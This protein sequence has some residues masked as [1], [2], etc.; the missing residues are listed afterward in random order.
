M[1]LPIAT[2]MLAALVAASPAGA[3]PLSRLFGSPQLAALAQ[4]R[5][6]SYRRMVASTIEGAAATVDEPVRLDRGGGGA[7]VE[8]TLGEGDTARR[9]PPFRGMTGNPILMVFLE[10]VVGAASAASGGSPFYLRSRIKEAMRERMAETPVS[11]GLGGRTVPG[12]EISLRPFEGDPHAAELGAF[13]DLRLSFVMAEAA[14]G[15]FVSLAAT[16]GPG[17]PAFSEEIR[18]DVPQ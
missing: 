3:D 1:R 14:P 13:A 17:T 4:D 5:P 12:H 10:S 7:H 15:T 11:V 18:L 8:V 9:L 6:L 2:A 16:T